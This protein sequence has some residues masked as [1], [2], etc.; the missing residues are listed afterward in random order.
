MLGTRPA[1]SSITDEGATDSVAPAVTA[2]DVWNAAHDN[3]SP[4]VACWKH[5]PMWL[6][7]CYPHHPPYPDI[8]D[9]GN[10]QK[11][12]ISFLVNKQIKHLRRPWGKQLESC[13]VCTL[14]WSTSTSTACEIKQQYKQYGSFG[15]SINKYIWMTKRLPILDV[16]NHAGEHPE[17]CGGRRSFTQGLMSCYVTTQWHAR[18]PHSQM[19]WDHRMSKHQSSSNICYIPV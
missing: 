1:C 18:P 15:N 7:L 17:Y 4:L 3:Y 12:R 6:P 9:S 8:P 13:A 10:K 11:N 2:L 16:L 5:F 19:C 14:N